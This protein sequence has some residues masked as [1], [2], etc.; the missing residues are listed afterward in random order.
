MTAEGSAFR[1]SLHQILADSFQMIAFSQWSARRILTEGEGV[2][3]GV[4]PHASLPRHAEEVPAR[5][6][7]DEMS[8]LILI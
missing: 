8:T 6:L 3:S 1:G 5:N 2:P 7:A 4:P